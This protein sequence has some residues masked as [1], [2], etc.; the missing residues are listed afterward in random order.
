M[1]T[2]TATATAGHGVNI[3][4]GFVKY[5]IA[6]ADGSERL[7]LV[8]PAMIAR[9][10]RTVA[11]ALARAESVVMGDDFW[12]TGEDALLSPAPLTYLGQERLTDDIF[13]PALLRGALQ[14][15]GQ[16]Q[17]AGGVCV[18]GLPAAWA[19]DEGKARALGERI[20]AA[21]PGYRSIRVI[22]EPLGLVY[23]ALLDGAGAVV[24]DLALTGGRVGVIDLGHHTDDVCVVD[25]MRPIA[26]SLA[27]FQTG[28]AR[29]LAQIAT[30]LGEAYERELTLAEADAAV[31]ARQ[32]RIA[33]GAR[34]LPEGWA[35]PLVENGAALARRLV[36]RWGRG[37]DLDAILIGG[38]GA[39]LP[40]KV[41]AIQDRFP[42]ARVVAQPQTAVAR[43]YARL[44]RRLAGEGR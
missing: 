29:P 38:G 13:I 33:G 11:G 32:V 2:L 10:G 14:R 36:E 44:A 35:E 15:L 23:A 27:T 21:Q 43:G 1:L 17:G 18:T 24:G 26:S 34:P 31:R 19:V 37:A 25:R 20:R 30:L 40:Q 28:T 9:A 42:H 4:H 8:F 3:G 16:L 22:P 12:W 41:Q 6:G 5:V 39:E 7:P